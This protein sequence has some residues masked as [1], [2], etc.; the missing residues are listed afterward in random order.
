MAFMDFMPQWGNNTQDISGIDDDLANQLML[1]RKLAQAE[2]LR[3]QQVPQGQMVGDRYVAPSW[4]QYLANVYGKM[5]SAADERGAIKEYGNIVSSKNKKIAN[6]LEDLSKGKEV[7]QPVD[8]NE[9][10]NMPGMMQTVRKPYSQQEFMSKVGAIMPETLPKF[11]QAQFEQYNKDKTPIK[12]S[13]GDVFFDPV[14]HEQ[15]F[16]VP[17]KP[18]AAL[19][20]IQPDP[21]TGKF[22]GYDKDKNQIVEVPGQAV[23]PKPEVPKAPPSRT[24]NISDTMQVE[25]VMTSPPTKENPQGTWQATGKPY[26]R[27]APEKPPKPEKLKEI[28]PTP[29]ASYAANIASIRQ[30]DDAIKAV[31]NAPEDYFGLVGGLGNTYM[32]R[33]K[34]GSVDVR[35]KVTSIGA[36]KR[37]ELS[38]SAVTPSESAETAPMLPR[39]TDDKKTTL[40]KLR[41]LRNNYQMTNEAIAGSFGPE[42]NPINAGYSQQPQQTKSSTPP[43]NLLSEG[44]VTKFTNGQSWTLKNGKPMKVSE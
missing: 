24:R 26:S 33:M 20:N 16:S 11:L 40:T 8:Y 12:G 3:N 21:I 43:L 38:G 5:Q 4:T 31:E 7:E 13:A 6:L 42:Y 30:I 9:A 19:S 39:P 22:Y 36:V 15:I 27:F 35:G 29:R 34:P 37:H 25:E 32:S 14:T 18:Q 10:G 1:K 17:S 41:N 23:T 44:K 2:A 28:P